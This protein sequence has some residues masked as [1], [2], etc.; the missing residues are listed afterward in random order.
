MVEQERGC[1]VARRRV[2]ERE[3]VADVRVRDDEVD[4][5]GAPAVARRRR[6][7]RGRPAAA[8]APAAATTK[9]PRSRPSARPPRVRVEPAERGDERVRDGRPTP[10]RTARA[11]RRR[12]RASFEDARVERGEELAQQRVAAVRAGRLAAVAVE[13]AEEREVD[14]RAAQPERGR[15]GAVARPHAVGVRDVEVLAFA[16]RGLGLAVVS[17]LHAAEG[18]HIS[19]RWHSP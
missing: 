13:D 2:E 18:R 19:N 1:L 11:A 16:R 15:V 10:R 3:R 7:R 17:Y 14:G 4:G 9:T 12:A 6:A 8:P 5:Y